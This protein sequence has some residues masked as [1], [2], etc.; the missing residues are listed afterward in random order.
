MRKIKTRKEQRAEL[1]AKILP[2]K[3]EVTETYRDI[4][5]LSKRYESAIVTGRK[6]IDLSAKRES[7]QVD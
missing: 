2:T 3:G 6:N 7:P 5:A 1:I 4:T